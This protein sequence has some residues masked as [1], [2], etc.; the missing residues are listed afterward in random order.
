M[1]AE[2]IIAEIKK[3]DRDEQMLRERR[4]QLVSSLMQ[5][6]GD[7]WD[8]ITVRTA[9]SK[10]GRSVTFLYDRIKEGRLSVKHHGSLKL[11]RESEIKSMDDKYKG[12]RNE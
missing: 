2:A 9:S 6:D 1:N 4:M 10:S 12:G 11:V 3:I 5:A 7:D 8:W